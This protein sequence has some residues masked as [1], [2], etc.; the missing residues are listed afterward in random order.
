MI[1]A[2]WWKVHLF[3]SEWSDPETSSTAG[4]ACAPLIIL[5][6]RGLL[7][8]HRGFNRLSTRQCHKILW[9]TLQVKTK[10]AILLSL[11]LNV[12]EQKTVFTKVIVHGRYKMVFPSFGEF[13]QKKFPAF[14]PL[15]EFQVAVGQLTMLLLCARAFEIPVKS[16]LKVSGRCKYTHTHTQHMTKRLNSTSRLHLVANQL[17]FHKL[18][19]CPWE[20]GTASSSGRPQS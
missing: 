20:I 12:L 16:T 10:L 6:G 18:W 15:L 11:L 5:P 3:V 7:S 2:T 8:S 9:Q 17:T 14:Y 4:S 1:D 19:K 13:H